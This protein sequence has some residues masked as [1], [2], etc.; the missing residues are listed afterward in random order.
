MSNYRGIFRRSLSAVFVIGFFLSAAS[1]S[2]DTL[3]SG[4]FIV[5]PVKQEL[6]LTSNSSKTVTVKLMNGTQFPLTVT[7]SYEDIAATTQATPSDDPVKL[8]GKGSSKDSL[9]S[10]IDFPKQSF[11]L[12]SGKEIEIPVTIK[13]P[14]NAPAGG[15]YGSIV[16]NFKRVY[17]GGGTAN[18]AVE[19]RIASLYFVRIEGA[20]NEDGAL[21]SFALFNNA[22]RAA[23][24][25]A[26]DPLRFAVTYENKGDVYLNPYGR[27]TVSGMLASPKVLIVDPWAVLPTATRI[28]EVDLL[29]SLMPG[30]YHAHLELNRGYKDIVDERDITF[31][32]MPTA[33]EWIVGLFILLLLILLIRRS[34]AL[35]RH[36]ISS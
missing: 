11:D 1:V 2:A 22:Q 36:S 4:A 35:S 3:P 33:T 24:P 25:S 32:I 12:L 6:T 30:Y 31:W 14:N 34:L 7:P 28:R 20:S 15:R 10:F 13:I 26:K 23:Q 16:W 5:A 27:I 17:V 19:S 29:E 21:T 9:S 8:L 18:V